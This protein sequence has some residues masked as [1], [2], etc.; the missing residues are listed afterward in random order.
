MPRTKA[1]ADRRQRTNT[2]AAGPLTLV[3]S[4]Q[5]PDAPKPPRGTL[6]ATTKDA[7]VAFWESEVAGL[8]S[9]KS[10]MPALR[11][12]FLLYDERER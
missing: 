9:P 2:P 1:P 11:R 7:W 10:D 4:D 3:P 8:V 5:A 6:L 12:L